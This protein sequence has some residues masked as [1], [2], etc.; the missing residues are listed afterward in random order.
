MIERIVVK[1]DADRIEALEKSGALV[2]RDDEGEL[3]CV[4]TDDA[5][6]TEFDAIGCRPVGRD[7][8]LL[9]CRRFVRRPERTGSGP[10][11]CVLTQVSVQRGP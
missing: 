9:E 5:F 1:R 8:V 4:G 11:F 7:D 3:A 6:G 2:L 10:A